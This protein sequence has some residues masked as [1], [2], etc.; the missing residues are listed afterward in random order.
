MGSHHRPQDERD[1]ASSICKSA[2]V[3]SKVLWRGSR[4]SIESVA[5]WA[6]YMAK[7]LA[8]VARKFVHPLLAVVADIALADSNRVGGTGSLKSMK[9]WEES[10]PHA[11]NTPEKC[12]K[13][14]SRDFFL[15]HV[16]RRDGRK[17]FKVTRSDHPDWAEAEV[18]RMGGKILVL[19]K[20]KQ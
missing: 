10:T 2:H 11:H 18:L 12:P 14:G 20:A 19:G 6:A 17:T 5:K 3:K 4:G 16:E 13:C 8:L 9:K 15:Q 7:G 1:V